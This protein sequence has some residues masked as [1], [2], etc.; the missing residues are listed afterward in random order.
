MNYKTAKFGSNPKSHGRRK[1]KEVG[2]TYIKREQASK[3]VVTDHALL[4][5]KIIEH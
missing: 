5:Q 4:Q 3:I 1:V 2:R